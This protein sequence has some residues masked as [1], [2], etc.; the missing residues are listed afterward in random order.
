MQEKLM[1]LV[2]GGVA[3]NLMLTRDKESIWGHCKWMGSPHG[4]KSL[5][6]QNVW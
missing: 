5:I 2:L 4:V 1:S 3:S 6:E